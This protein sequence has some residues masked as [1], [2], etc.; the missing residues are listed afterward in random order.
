M[1]GRILITFFT[2]ISEDPI[3]DLFKGAQ[4][5]PHQRIREDLLKNPPKD[6]RDI[7]HKDPCNIPHKDPHNIP[8]KNPHNIPHKDPCSIPHKDSSSPF[9]V[10]LHI[11]ERSYAITYKFV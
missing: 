6:P 4:K 11:S 7:P 5:D 3:E 8:H 1:I 2:M 10:R 9:I